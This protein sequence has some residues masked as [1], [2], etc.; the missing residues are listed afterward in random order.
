LQI[1]SKQI[2]CFSEKSLNLLP[3]DYDLKIKT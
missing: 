1:E 3:E 2:V